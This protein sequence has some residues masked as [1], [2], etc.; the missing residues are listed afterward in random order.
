MKRLPI[1]FSCVLSI[2]AFTACDDDT[3]TTDPQ[4]VSVVPEVDETP[5][6]PQAVRPSEFQEEI[7]DNRTRDYYG[8]P[9]TAAPDLVRAFNASLEELT[10]QTR[11]RFEVTPAAR[12]L[13]LRDVNV[14]VLADFDG[15]ELADANRG[16]REDYIDAHGVGTVPFRTKRQ[17]YTF[18]GLEDRSE[19]EIIEVC[20]AVSE[21]L[22]NVPG[23]ITMRGP[24]VFVGDHY[25]LNE[26]GNRSIRIPVFYN[27]RLAPGE[28]GSCTV[29]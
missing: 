21:F 4:A 3:T 1:S 12:S 7:P 16:T 23:Y 18:D 22:S 29:I 9:T 17:D 26:F 24:V 8:V 11:N 20:E 28:P 6:D 10:P 27:D 14:K 25:Q 13:V 5:P 15:I 19:A 2:L